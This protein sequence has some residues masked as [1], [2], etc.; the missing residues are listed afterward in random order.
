MLN[1]WWGCKEKEE[2][3][4]WDGCFGK[5][6]AVQA[7][8]PEFR[9]LIIA[10]QGEGRDSRIL[11]SLTSQPSKLWAPGSVK[12]TV[13]QTEAWNDHGKCLTDLWPPHSIPPPTGNMHI[14]HREKRETGDIKKLDVTIP[15]QGSLHP[16]KTGRPPTWPHLKPHANL[17]LILP[18]WW[19]PGALSDSTPLLICWSQLPKACGLS[20]R[21]PG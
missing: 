11:G 9:F 18:F 13:S 17:S 20:D 12:D 19:G 3:G 16:V 5:L 7:W 2:E 15:S 14:T 4:W 8:E 1:S 6:L 10:W 21:L